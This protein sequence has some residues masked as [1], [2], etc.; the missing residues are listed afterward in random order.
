MIKASIYSGSFYKWVVLGLATFTQASATLV[1]YGVGP[2]ALFWQDE[3]HLTQMETGLLLSA[4][5]I[6]PLFFMLFVGRLLDQFNE[7]LLIGLGSILLGLSLLA[8]T[9]VDEYTRLIA[10]L[11]IIGAFYSTA[12]PGGSKVVIKWFPRQNRGLAMGIRQAGI[13]I[14][15]AMSGMIVPFISLEY[16]WHSAVYFLS[17]LCMFGGAIFLLFYKEP[18]FHEAA[19]A[20]KERK[21]LRKQLQEIVKNKALYPI[22]FSGVTMISLQLIIVG[23][24]TIFFTHTGSITHLVAGQLFSV[25]LFFGM[26]GRVLL[27]SASDSM[28]KGDRRTPLFL[29]VLAALLSV[30]MISMNLESF[31]LWTL[32]ILCAWLGFFGIGWYSLYIAEVAEKS[33]HDSVGVTVSFALTLNQLAI[34][35]A[36]PIFGLLTDMKG[37]EFGWYCI[38][39][40]LLLSGL[41]LI[42]KNHFY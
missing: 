19:S 34:I 42:K 21:T 29:S 1:T 4:V 20:A 35:A 25:T 9:I 24:L 12:Q 28:F 40:F 27:A 32:Y 13:P 3:F 23:H 30:L 22:F 39:F 6:G 8:A 16:G 15:G 33:V 18:S 38:A 37:Y 31:P 11:F 14:G 26:A 17:G 36:P 5:N 10:V 7:R 2:L 41:W